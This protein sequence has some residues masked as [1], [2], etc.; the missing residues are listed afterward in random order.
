MGVTPEIVKSALRTNALRSSLCRIG[1]ASDHQAH[2]RAGSPACID[3]R[4]SATPRLPPYS[5]RTFTSG[6]ASWRC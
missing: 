3:T 2:H 1:Q 6:S 5:W 4:P